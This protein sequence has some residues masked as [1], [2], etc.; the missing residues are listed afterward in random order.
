MLSAKY[1]DRG[2][3]KWAAFDA[4]NGFNSM[5][6]EM[7]RRLGKSEKPI[8]S[9]DD[10]D[11]MNLALQEALIK[12]TEIAV[13]YFEDGYSK[14]SFGMIKKLD[15]DYKKVI[16]STKESISAFDILNIENI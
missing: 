12:K 4:L 13:T 11:R 16:L 9:E 8:L 1:R 6:T 3:I 2:I 5:L 10:F 7:R 14:T 15:F